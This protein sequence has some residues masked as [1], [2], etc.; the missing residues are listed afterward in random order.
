M[1]DVIVNK[2]VVYNPVDYV[3]QLIGGIWKTPVLWRLKN[4]MYR[5][6]EL[7]KDIP[8]ISQ[9]ML[10]K[11]LKGLEADWLISKIMYAEVPPRSEYLIINKGRKVVLLIESI[12]NCGISLMMDDGIDYEKMIVQEALLKK[13]NKQ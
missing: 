1:P 10:T 4:K 8:H 5:Y 11:A 6:T 12:R 2:Y 13:K 3:L 9:K 7:E